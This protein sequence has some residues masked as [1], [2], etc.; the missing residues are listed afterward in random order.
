MIPDHPYL[1]RI[2]TQHEFD[3]LVEKAK[4]EKHGVFVPTHPIFKNGNMVGYFSIGSPGVPLVL[5]W[6][7]KEINARESFNL[8]NTVE[9]LVAGGVSGPANAVVF[10]VPKDSPFHPLMEG[11]GF[12]S[13]GVYEFFVKEL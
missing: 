2:K 4:Q 6:L 10:P 1:T 9:N 11:M 13:A 5:A 7:S 3:L 8:I 12:K